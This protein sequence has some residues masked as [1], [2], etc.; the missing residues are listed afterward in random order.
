MAFLL[1]ELRNEFFSLESH[2]A[3]FTK[4]YYRGFNFIVKY[5]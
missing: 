2:V 3:D 5:V 1:N 4:N